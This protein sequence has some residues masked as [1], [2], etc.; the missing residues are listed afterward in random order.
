MSNNRWC[1][2]RAVGNP[3][4]IGR[5]LRERV[6]KIRLVLACDS[7][8]GNWAGQCIQRQTGRITAEQRII[9][10]KPNYLSRCQ[11]HS[12]RR[13]EHQ[14]WR[15]RSGSCG[16]PGR[17]F[18]V[19]VGNKVAVVSVSATALLLRPLPQLGRRGCSC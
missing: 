4:A 13:H 7:S 14:G 3:A 11:R 5:K 18:S 10:R 16:Y 19:S 17:L 15:Q 9:L 2:H 12:Y 6:A 8:R 1:F